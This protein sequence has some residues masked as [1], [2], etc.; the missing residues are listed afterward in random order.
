YPGFAVCRKNRKRL[1]SVKNEVFTVDVFYL[2][3]N[4]YGFPQKK[5]KI[6]KLALWAWG[7]VFVR[8]RWL[9]EV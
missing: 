4:E 6:E 8:R 1:F 5:E 7:I 2:C 9:L 3:Y